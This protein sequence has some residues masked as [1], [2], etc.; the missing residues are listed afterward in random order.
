MHPDDVISG[1]GAARLGGRFV[2]VGTKAV[3]ASDS[4][5]TLLQEMSARKSR[6]GGKA[7]IDVH[8]YPRV[9]FRIDL[10]LSRCI[11]FVDPFGNHD[12]ENIRRRCL[13]IDDLAPSQVVGRYFVENGVQAVLYPSMAGSGSNVVVFV[14]NSEL[15]EVVLFNRAKIISDLSAYEGRKRPS[16]P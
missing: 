3:F 2:A 12:L 16:K 8:P 10:R 14:K 6:L 9:T 7:F 15:G 13:Q 4:E 11:S 1:A 5:E